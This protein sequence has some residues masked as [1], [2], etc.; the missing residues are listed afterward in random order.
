MW[1]IRPGLLYRS[2]VDGG[3]I[4]DGESGQVHHLN[5][6]AAQVWELCRAGATSAVLAA[7]LCSQYEVES[8]QAQADVRRIIQVFADARLLQP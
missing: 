1:Q 4:Y 5:A 6:S 7:A 2:L 8:A 3:M